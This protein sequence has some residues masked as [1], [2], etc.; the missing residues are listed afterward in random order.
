MELVDYLKAQTVGGP[1]EERV[2]Q[3]KLVK[4]AGKDYAKIDNRTALWGPILGADTLAVGTDI[5]VVI[6]QS[7][8]LYVVYPPTAAPPDPG[9]GDDKNFVHTQGSPSATWNIT[10]NLGKYPAVDVVDTG[11]SAVI[12]T[13]VYIDVNNV[14]LVFGSATSGKAFMN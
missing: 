5:V 14:Q 2:L 12:P 1:D 6:D 11:G 8:K 4:Q 3:G 9:T 10:H 13:V 7:N